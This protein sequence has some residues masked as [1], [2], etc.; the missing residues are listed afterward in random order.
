MKTIQGKTRFG[1]VY[2]L[3]DRQNRTRKFRLGI[4]YSSDTY[5]NKLLSFYLGYYILSFYTFEMKTPK[6]LWYTMKFRF[7]RWLSKTETRL[8]HWYRYNFENKTI[9]YSVTSMDCDCCESTSFGIHRN[10][11]EY[12]D[13]L[14]DES[15]WD[16]VEGRTSVDLHDKD[17]WEYY[18]D[19]PRRTR[20]YIMEAY[21]D[22]RGTHVNI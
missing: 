7:R 22:G 1:M 4:R 12:Y 18:N 14:N 13:W 6:Q 9:Y 19:Q 21:E 16:W 20:D 2:I 8:E 15:E 17:E 3:Q 10:Y 5:L 11:R